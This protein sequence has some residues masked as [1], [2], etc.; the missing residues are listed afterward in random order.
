M[1]AMHAAIKILHNKH[2]DYSAFTTGENEPDY[3]GPVTKSVQLS[4]K[5]DRDIICLSASSD[6]FLYKMVRRIVGALVEVGKGRLSPSDIATASRQQIPTAPPGGLSL[7]EVVYP[8]RCSEA[9]GILQVAQR[10]KKHVETQLRCP[11]QHES[12]LHHVR[13][14]P[15]KRRLH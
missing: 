1:E 2:M 11:V 5:I 14:G 13:Y 8:K 15:N 3:H 7:D 9:S 4:M 10:C 6:R 12:L